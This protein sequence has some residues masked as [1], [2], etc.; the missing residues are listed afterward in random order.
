MDSL[1]HTEVDG[2]RT[3]WSAIPGP[4][5]AGLVVRL[6]AADETFL[7]A[8]ISHLLEHLAL[9]GL[10]RPGDHSNGYV[11]QTRMVFLAEGDEDEIQHFLDSLTRQLAEPPLH[12]LED[13][14]G[15]LKA[16]RARQRPALQ[17]SQDLWRYGTRSYGLMGTEQ[18]GVDLVSPNQLQ[19]WSAR[20]A[21][22][23]N[24]V[25][26]LSGPPPAGLSLHLPA[27]TAQPPPDPRTGILSQFP[28]WFT[29][30]DDWAAFDCLLPR[31]PATAALASILEGRLVDDLRSNRAVAYSP[32]TD[33]RPLTL[34]V[35]R[36]SAF[37][38]L[39]AGRQ[40]EAI[41]PFLTALEELSSD[42]GSKG[43]VREEELTQWL[44]RFRRRAA[45]PNYGLSLL[46]T[47][48]CDMAS[49]GPPVVADEALDRARRVIPEQVAEAARLGQETLLAQVPSGLEPRR[50]S[51][52]AAPS[53]LYADLSGRPFRSRFH[54]ERSTDTIHIAPAGI[55][56]RTGS[57]NHTVTAA[58]TV[59]VIRWDDGRR[60]LIGGDGVRV[61][62]EPTLWHDGAQLVGH[63]DSAWPAELVVDRGARPASSIPQPDPPPVVPK[64]Y[65]R[66]LLRAGGWTLAV[67]VVLLLAAML[68]EDVH[69]P[70]GPV[71]VGGAVAVAAYRRQRRSGG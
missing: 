39:V 62:V 53:S 52:S 23:S 33:H 29:G 48:A 3:V 22:R 66:R 43:A 31:S 24:S 1:H 21:N 63:V 8:G 56:L 26:W 9:F 16:E 34:E 18:F 6:G 45:D 41:R 59:A 40:A 2:V 70:V 42:L 12:R 58:D 25:L 68:Q 4:L 20:F 32:G 19:E 38:D 65:G 37:T 47:V 10:G 54:D 49:G 7:T 57:G 28:A 60:V 46:N 36:L 35:V 15:V 67:V 61:L 51:W 44:N 14:R 13:E 55:T 64:R 30:P 5:R 71:L 11:D 50:E 69:L 27:G 17:D